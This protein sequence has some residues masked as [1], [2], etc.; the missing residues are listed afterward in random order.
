LN[1]Y[2]QNFIHADKEEHIMATPRKSLNDRAAGEIMLNEVFKVVERLNAAAG[3][4]MAEKGV[5]SG[6]MTFN[7][8]IVVDETGDRRYTC[9][10]EIYTPKSIDGG[11]EISM[12][13]S[14]DDIEHFKQAVTTV[15]TALSSLA[16]QGYLSDT[17]TVGLIKANGEETEIYAPKVLEPGMYSVKEN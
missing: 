2:Q 1:K 14:G 10:V 7:P 9:Y 15:F 4:S 8:R 12:D 3:P 6:N 16:K 17:F 11:P 13:F 5:R